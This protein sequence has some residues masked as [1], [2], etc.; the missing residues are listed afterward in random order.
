M[1]PVYA[2]VTVT[3]ESANT[4]Y[5]A[6]YGSYVDILAE[7]N[8]VKL[9]VIGTKTYGITES[10]Y[11]KQTQTYTVTTAAGVKYTIRIA[12]GVA[13]VTEV[14]AAEEGQQA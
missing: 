10:V 5:T 9:L 8:T 1:I 11:D 14:P 7:S 6:D 2:S 3:E 13:E 12:G 4:Y